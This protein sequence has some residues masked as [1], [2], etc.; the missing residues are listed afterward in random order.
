MVK[1]N[2][3][4]T[5]MAK[6]ARLIG[7]SGHYY[8]LRMEYYGCGGLIVERQHAELKGKMKG[9]TKLCVLIAYPQHT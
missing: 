1:H 7:I 9:K 5:V 4:R 2:L 6:Y 3:S 8:G